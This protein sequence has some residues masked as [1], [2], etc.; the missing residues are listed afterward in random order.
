MG[1]GRDGRDGFWG[2]PE[3]CRDHV[4]RGKWRPTSG[5]MFNRSLTGWAG[6]RWVWLAVG[7]MGVR[8]D[9]LDGIGDFAAIMFALREWLPNSRIGY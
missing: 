4:G 7:G 2:I 9:G 6:G 1:V 5:R 8:R 3:R